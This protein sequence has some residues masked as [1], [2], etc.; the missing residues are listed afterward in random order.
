[1][2]CKKNASSSSSKPRRTNG[3][4]RP[5]HLLQVL[6]WIL[7]LVLLALYFAF[8]Y[9]LLWTVNSANVALTVV[10][11]ASCALAIGAGYTTCAIDPIDDA[12]TGMNP[13]YFIITCSNT[14][15][16]ISLGRVITQEE[17]H[18]Y[19]YICSTNVHETS[20]HCRYCDKCVLRFDHHCKWFVLT[21]CS[22]LN[23]CYYESGL[24][25]SCLQVEYLCGGEE[26]PVL[27][28]HL[29]GRGTHDHSP[30][31]HQHRLVGWSL[32]LRVQT[33]NTM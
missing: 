23:P 9:P 19:C 12:L 1:M 32:C 4:E 18:L 15:T 28:A 25:W 33:P 5:L 17:P 20:K 10:F 14:F 16:Y 21:Y 26:L 11:C 6:T 13:R 2:I 22:L 30:A 3:F 27:P 8:L 24:T 31:C 7:L 29:G